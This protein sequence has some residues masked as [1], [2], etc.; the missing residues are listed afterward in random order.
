MS[1][2]RGVTNNH[3]IRSLGGFRS[4]FVTPCF[5]SHWYSIKIPSLVC[6]SYDFI[7]KYYS[8]PSSFFLVL[9]SYGYIILLPHPHIGILM[10]YKYILALWYVWRRKRIRLLVLQSA[11]PKPSFVTF[12]KIALEVIFCL[13]FLPCLNL[14]SV[15]QSFEL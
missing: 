4:C 14:F 15:N 10:N 9:A 5:L 1:A 8:L 11:L 7:I 2:R 6:H 13:F 3:A 12:M